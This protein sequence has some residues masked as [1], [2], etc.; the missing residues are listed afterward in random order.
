MLQQTQVVT[1]LPYY[2]R[3]VAAFPNVTALANAPLDAVMRLW[4]GLGYYAR[5]RNL[6]ACA[7]RIVE[8]FNG[9]FPRTQRVLATL[10]GI[11]RSTAAAI[12]AFCWSERAAI[13]DGNVKRVLAR[14]FAVEGRVGSATVEREMWK[15]A[16][17]L[18]PAAAQMPAYTQGVMDIGATICTR[19]KP[20]CRSCPLHTTCRAVHQ[21]RVAELPTPPAPRPGRQRRSHW[22]VLLHD[23][24]ALL[25]RR[26]PTGLWGGLLTLPEFGSAAALRR[27]LLLLDPQ[28]RAAAMAARRHA[29]TH[30]TLQFTPHVARLVRLAAAEEPGRV[31]LPLAEIDSAALPAP[32]RTLLR[33]VHGRPLRPHTVRP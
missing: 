22:L 30:F 14:H 13:L 16:E 20:A 32:V 17:G 25:E 29:F 15:L 3:F 1:V 2:E 21:N 24:H 9:E 12:A 31:W 6:H 7:V 27:A 33:D 5:A 11:G 26:A 8:D 28:A 18:L 23:D 4:S 19:T 10:P